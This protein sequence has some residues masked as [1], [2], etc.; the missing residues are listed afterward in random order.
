MN[1]AVRTALI[2]MLAAAALTAQQ[3]LSFEAASVKKAEAGTPPGDVA[4]NMDDS[5]GH[6]AMRNIPLRFALEWAY[7]IKD[8]QLQAPAW[9]AGEERYDIIATAPGSTADQ[10]QQM[11]RTLIDERFQMKSHWETK[12]LQCYVLSPGKGAN[13]L[14]PSEGAPSLG[15]GGAKGALFHNQPVS[16]FTFMLT[17]RLDRPVLDETGLKGTYDFTIDL[18]GLGFGGR[19]AEDTGAP[20]IFSTVQSDLGLKLESAKRPIKV[21]VVDSANKNPTAN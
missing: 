20:S 7:D 1:E 4:R 16:R 6:F 14:K 2:F 8:Y 13:K 12:D 10:M 17:R 19:A 11:L 21:F 18:S 5:P 15:N 9:V 3:K